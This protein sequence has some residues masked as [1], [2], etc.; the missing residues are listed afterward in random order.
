MW[1]IGGLGILGV[2]VAALAA[3]MVGGAMLKRRLLGV[4]PADLEFRAADPTAYPLADLDALARYTAA[5]E[6]LGFVSV[7]DYTFSARDAAVQPAF[8]R[9]FVHPENACYVEANQIF[10]ANRPPTPLRSAIGTA[11]EGG[12]SLGTTDRAPDAVIY[13]LR[14]PRS[15][16][17][18]YEGAVPEELL[19][20]HLELR[21]RLARDLGLRPRWD[22]SQNA[23]FAI[24]CEH[25]LARK[26]AFAQRN[27]FAFLFE[28]AR[29]GKSPP[30]EWLGDYAKRAAVRR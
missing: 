12:W 17:T 5:Y 9:L 3:A 19:A 24:E 6:A 22:T 1:G 7:G 29:L 11:F 21:D 26:R 14:R 10:P 13:A 8:A 4:I 28:L 27:V 20:R 15:L 23:Y 2:A 16:W 25:A 18:S 30:A